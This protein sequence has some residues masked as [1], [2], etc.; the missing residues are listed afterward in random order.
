MT[1]VDKFFLICKRYGFYAK[2]HDTAYLDEI[3]VKNVMLKAYEKHPSIDFKTFVKECV[4]NPI[5]YLYRLCE[6]LEMDYY[7]LHMLN[8][9]FNDKSNVHYGLKVDNVWY[10]ITHSKNAFSIPLYI[11]EFKIKPQDLEN[12]SYLTSYTNVAPNI[13]RRNVGSIKKRAIMEYNNLF[14]KKV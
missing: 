4:A 11:T 1:F 7:D 14:L 12:I 5:E 2:K 3:L 6:E 13:L 10:F 9:C 8:N